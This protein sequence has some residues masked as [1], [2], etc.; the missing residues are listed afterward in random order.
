MSRVHGNV[1]AKAVLA[2][3]VVSRTRVV[4][5]IIMSVARCESKPAAEAMSKK[6]EEHLVQ[7]LYYQQLERAAQREEERQAALKRQRDHNQ[8]NRTISKSQEE[9][10][11]H[12]VYNE[13]LE[14]MQQISAERERQKQMEAKKNVKKIDSSDLDSHIQ[15]MYDEA[16]E[17]SQ[18]RRARLEEQT[19][20]STVKSRTISKRELAESVQRLYH[21]DWEKRDEELFKKHV[22]PNDPPVIRMSSD[23][24]RESST[25]LYTGA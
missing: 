3:L 20:K 17:R 8:L 12:R 11:V 19:Y 2:Y 4:S 22:Y 1:S 15:H 14:R 7:R 21:V 9:Q 24:I 16:I 10:L 18:Q 6:E 5:P 13:Q 23:A 25:R